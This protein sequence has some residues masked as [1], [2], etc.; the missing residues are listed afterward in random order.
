ML[1]CIGAGSGKVFVSKQQPTAI[2]RISVALEMDS[3]Q[4]SNRKHSEQH[5]NGLRKIFLYS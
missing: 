1:V 5:S 2:K 3:S 4:V